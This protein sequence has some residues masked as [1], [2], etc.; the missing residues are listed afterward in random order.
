[1]L[2]KNNRYVL[3]CFIDTVPTRVPRK[4]EHFGKSKEIPPGSISF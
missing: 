1:M 4:L 2:I 3:E